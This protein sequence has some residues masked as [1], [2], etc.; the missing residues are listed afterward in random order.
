MEGFIPIAIWAVI[1]LIGGAL[2]MMVVFG[3]RNVTYGKIQ[4]LSVAMVAVPVLL[5]VVLGMTMDDWGHAG[6]LTLLI[7]LSLAALSLL[8][9]GMRTMLGL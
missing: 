8:L 3:I 2:L 7:M 6:I 9:S 1:I 4:P 5:L